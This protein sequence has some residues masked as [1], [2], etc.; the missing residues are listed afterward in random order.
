MVSREVAAVREQDRDSPRAWGGLSDSGY[1]GQNELHS[2]LEVAMRN[3][4]QQDK[5]TPS[6][7]MERWVARGTG[8][9]GRDNQRRDSWLLRSYR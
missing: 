9:K 2:D 5:K 3:R 7:I 6:N 4:R 1:T 8:L